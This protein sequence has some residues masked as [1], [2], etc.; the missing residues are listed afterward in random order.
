MSKIIK[1]P[2]NGEVGYDATAEQI[3]QFYKIRQKVDDWLK[4]QDDNGITNKQKI[5]QA[6][7]NKTKERLGYVELQGEEWV[8]TDKSVDDIN[9]WFPV[10]WPIV[11][12]VQSEQLQR[13]LLVNQSS[14]VL[15]DNAAYNFGPRQPGENEGEDDG[16]ENYIFSA[17]LGRISNELR[18]K[19]GFLDAN[20]WGLYENQIWTPQVEGTTVSGSASKSTQKLRV[21]VWC[22]AL[23]SLGIRE[24]DASVVSDEFNRNS[25]IDLTPFI[26]NMSVNQTEQSGSFSISLPPV[27][28]TMSCSIGNR[29]TGL[30]QIDEN[31]YT[32]FMENNVANYVFK[33]PLNY[34][35]PED[36]K[37]A[38]Y[39]ENRNYKAPTPTYGKRAQSIEYD[40]R[41]NLRD[42][43]PGGDD[44]NFTKFTPAW[45]FREDFFFHNVISE[46]DIVFIGGEEGSKISSESD[47]VRSVD[48]IVNLHNVQIALVDTNSISTTAENTDVSIQIAG[49]D[50]MKVLIEDGSFF[51]QKSYANPKQQQTAFNNVDLPRRGDE[52]NAF[53][54]ASEKGWSGVNRLVTTGLIESMYN[55]DAR[56]IGFIMNL[57]VSRLSNI[58]ICQSKVFDSY[59]D[60]RTKFLVE[61]E[62]PVQKKDGKGAINA[63]EGE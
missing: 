1:L 52:V 26:Q 29:P 24:L 28:G 13:D 31:Y 19:W 50:L 17:A 61:V 44:G 42:T 51:F 12:H 35:M 45:W 41:V 32:K 10:P 40:S 47:F 58:E 63:N 7:D 30:W 57:L 11:L 15:V 20:G 39:D 55:V 60:L 43:P 9:A 59:G 53:N 6:Y 25:V 18:S 62:E 54:Q 4:T 38:W 33:S 14:L 3:H 37:N 22:K 21:W 5:L 2:Y 48:D 46:N 27:I 34:L 8:E 16:A 23:A 56:N 36:V 49:R